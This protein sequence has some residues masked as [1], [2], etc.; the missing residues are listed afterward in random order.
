MQPRLPSVALTEPVIK[1]YSERQL[2]PA[3][4]PLSVVATGMERNV[5][6]D[7][8]SETRKADE[9]FLARFDPKPD[10]GVLWT[11][12]SGIGQFVVAGW[13]ITIAGL[14]IVVGYAGMHGRGSVLA[15]AA[16]ILMTLFVLVGVALAAIGVR[17]LARSARAFWVAMRKALFVVSFNQA[18]DKRRALHAVV[19]DPLLEPYAR[20]LL[21][22]GD[23]KVPPL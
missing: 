19:G 8:E 21:Q 3:P 18:V 17:F 14:M 11:L 15:S 1:L 16:A 13:C 4:G 7:L 10:E 22:R 9:P 23:L 2:R 5:S 12:V 20:Y 6:G